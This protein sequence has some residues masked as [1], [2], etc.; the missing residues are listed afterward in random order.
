MASAGSN[1]D[2]Q[3]LLQD[4][5]AYMLAARLQASSRGFVYCIQTGCNLLMK[6]CVH[7]KRMKL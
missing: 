3:Q 5:L 7:H 2:A 4:L 6:A 1:S